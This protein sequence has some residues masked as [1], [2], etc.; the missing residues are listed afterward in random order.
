MN[1]FEGRRHSPP[2]RGGVDA[3][4]RRS[5]EASSYGADGVVNDGT[6]LKNASQ[7]FSTIS[8][9][10]SAPLRWLRTFLLMAQPPLL[11]QEGSCCSCSLLQVH[12]PRRLWIR[13]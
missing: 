13:H 10:P 1:K 8:T 12:S 9:T 7:K 2:Q 5:R 11:C 6:P 3:T 4:S